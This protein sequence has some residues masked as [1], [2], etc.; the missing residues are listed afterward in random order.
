QHRRDDPCAAVGGG[1]DHP[2][3]RGIHLV[4]RQGEAAHPL[5]DR[6]EL[7]FGLP[8][9]LQPFFRRIVLQVADQLLVRIIGPAAHLQATRQRTFGMTAY[10][11]RLQHHVPDRLEAGIDLRL[12]AQRF[13]VLVDDLR[14][15]LVLFRSVFRKIDTFYDGE[16]EFLELLE[17]AFGNPAFLLDH[18]SAADGVEGGMRL[19][20]VGEEGGEL[21][22]V[23]VEGQEVLVE[24]DVFL[25]V[26]V[27]AALPVQVQ[28]V[29]ELQV[30]HFGFDVLDGDRYRVVAQQTHDGGD[31]GSVPDPGE[32]EGA[33]EVD[34]YPIN[35]VEELG[36]LQFD[37]PSLGRTP[38][39]KGV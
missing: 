9:G 37:D 5:Q 3:Q 10:I 30:A 16:G 38:G 25:E 36:L 35:Q 26:E 14:D 24:D 21:H 28:A 20:S 39:P 34:S 22:P 31:V 1:G 7:H 32:R 15:L 18:K 33:V 23:G 29:E 17:L 8:D 13:L 12:A 4:H 11:H 6:P 27:D 2:S 19:L